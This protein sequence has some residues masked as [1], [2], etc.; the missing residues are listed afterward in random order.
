MYCCQQYYIQIKNISRFLRR[1]AVKTYP[2]EKDRDQ[3][4]KEAKHLFYVNESDEL[5]DVPGLTLICY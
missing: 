3:V 2:G 4:W 5:S 1:T